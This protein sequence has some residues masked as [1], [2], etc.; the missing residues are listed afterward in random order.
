MEEQQPQVNEV[1]PRRTMAKIEQANDLFNDES[2]EQMDDNP[3]QQSGLPPQLQSES[4]PTHLLAEHLQLIFELRSDMAEQRFRQEQMEL[5]LG[6]RH[7]MLTGSHKG[8]THQSRLAQVAIVLEWPAPPHH[9]GSDDAL[10]N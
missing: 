8:P 4:Q 7:D 5:M 1:A 10:V 3:H 6:V 2:R 9:H